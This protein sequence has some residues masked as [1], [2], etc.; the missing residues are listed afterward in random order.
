MKTKALLLIL[1][2]SYGAFSQT[3]KEL[4]SD[5]KKIYDANYTMDFDGITQL[6]Y[7][8]IVENFGKDKFPQKLD[9][10]YANEEFRM[11]LQLVMPVFQ[12]DMVQKIGGKTYCIVTYKNPVRYFFEAKL[13]ETTS[14]Q[15]A[16]M[17]KETNS[18]QEVTFE[19]QRNS[20]NVRRNSKYI[21]VADEST[22]NQWRFV[23]WDDAVQRQLFESV[24]GSELKKQLG[25]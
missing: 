18:T 5:I 21:A 17:L 10:D 9:H 1:F 25:L 4:K 2:I 8:K 12:Y 20:F 6:T 11:R 23:N 14:A 7:P 19:P 16:T 22:G 3:L 13:N 24:F 15:K